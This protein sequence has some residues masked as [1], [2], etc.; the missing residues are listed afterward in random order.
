M[1]A[2]DQQ[3]GA[4]ATTEGGL[5]LYAAGLSTL[6]L[7]HCLA[8]PL[9][10]TVLPIAGQ[11]SENELLHRALVLLAAPATLWVS[12][13]MLRRNGSLLFLVAACIGLALLVL[14]AFLEPMAAYEQPMT[15]TGA[16]LLAGAHLWRWSR[17]RHGGSHRTEPSAASERSDG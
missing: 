5:D 16:L 9:L 10:T 13:Q 7:L 1:T 2:H 12:W 8:L 15:V 6:C 3:L 11:L 14:A 17:H 4:I